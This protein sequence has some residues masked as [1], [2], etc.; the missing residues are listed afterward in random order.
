[1][2]KNQKK[3]LLYTSVSV[4]NVFEKET[5]IIAQI[6]ANE[7]SKCLILWQ[8]KTPTIVFPANKKW[9]ESTLL[10]TTLQKDDWKLLS[11][12]TGGA[13]VPQYQGIINLSHLYVWDDVT[14][15]SITQ[16]HENLCNKSL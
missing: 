3:L 14:P 2:V 13:P 1:M 5:A 15:Y 16:A 9:P 7:M 6:Q 12:K 4:A 11:R 8:T 10:K